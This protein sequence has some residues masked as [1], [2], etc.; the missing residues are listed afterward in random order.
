MAECSKRNHFGSLKIKP[1]TFK[2]QIKDVIASLLIIEE[3]QCYRQ[4]KAAAILTSRGTPRL[5]K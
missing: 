3:R 4:E 5:G 2:Q 1:L